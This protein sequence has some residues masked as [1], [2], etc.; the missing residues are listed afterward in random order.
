MLSAKAANRGELNFISHLRMTMGS[1]VSYFIRA[2]TSVQ[3]Y[4]PHFEHSVIN[5]TPAARLI[6]EL[7]VNKRGTIRFK[8]CFCVDSVSFLFRLSFF[9]FLL[10]FLVNLFCILNHIIRSLLL[11][12]AIFSSELIPQHVV[13]AMQRQNRNQKIEY[14]VCLCGFVERT[15]FQFSVHCCDRSFLF[16][17][18]VLLIFPLLLIPLLCPISE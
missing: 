17:F 7:N 12:R 4:R 6:F 18:F 10:V 16:A 14:I 13:T 2:H 15:S 9:R 5:K 1:S 8:L 3:W 11:R